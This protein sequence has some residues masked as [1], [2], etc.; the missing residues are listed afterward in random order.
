VYYK[1]VELAVRG[2]C[3]SVTQ[4]SC[5][6]GELEHR[7]NVVQSHIP[8]P[9]KDMHSSQSDVITHLQYDD[10]SVLRQYKTKT[11]HSAG[12]GEDSTARQYKVKTDHS[13]GYGEH[14]TARQ[15]KTKTDHSA[16]HGEDSTARQYKVKTDHSAGYGED[17]TARQYKTKTDHSAGHGE[18]S[19]ARQY[20]VKTDH[21]AGHG[22]DWTARQYNTKADHSAGHGEDSTARQ[23][24][25]KTDHSTGHGEDWTARQYNTK[26]DH[27]AG[28]GEDSIGKRYKVKT[29]HFA[30][31]KPGHSAGHSRVTDDVLT[32]GKSNIVQMM[33]NRPDMMERDSLYCNNESSVA[34]ESNIDSWSEVCDWNQPISTSFTSHVAADTINESLSSNIC[35]DI[36]NNEI[37]VPADTQMSHTANGSHQQATVSTNCHV[38]T[39]MTTYFESRPSRG[40]GLMNFRSLRAAK[41]SSMHGAPGKTS[42]SERVGSGSSTSFTDADVMLRGSNDAVHSSLSSDQHSLTDRHMADVHSALNGNAKHGGEQSTVNGDTA[43]SS[44][45][46][47]DATCHVPLTSYHPPMMPFSWSTVPPVCGV[48]PPGFAPPALMA[49]STLPMYPAYGYPMMPGSWPFFPSVHGSLPPGDRQSGLDKVD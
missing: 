12:H 8:P 43:Q 38:N 28:H 47:S 4:Y 5:V 30:G 7:H 6:N 26:A 19:T 44:S 23:Y 46:A 11:D 36:V 25:V 35:H 14:S 32:C 13:A 48:L 31:M 24:K 21:S 10:Y 27:S 42:G 40:R 17:S 15:Y 1:H 20:K 45:V 16:G 29:D 3:R 18:D 2:V 37:S 49:Y 41:I 33:T 9:A 34:S 22:E 39:D